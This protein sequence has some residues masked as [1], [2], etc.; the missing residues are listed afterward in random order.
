[1]YYCTDLYRF[2]PLYHRRAA[3][4]RKMYNIRGHMPFRQIDKNSLEIRF[5]LFKWLHHELQTITYGPYAIRLALFYLEWPIQNSPLWQK[6]KDGKANGY[7]KITWIW[8]FFCFLVETDIRCLDFRRL[9]PLSW[10]IFKGLFMAFHSTLYNSMHYSDFL[11][12][13]QFSVIQT[14]FCHE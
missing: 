1:M 8:P 9:S 14:H 6:A 7:M 11:L 5:S 13:T 3:P 12:S 2:C 10:S 4:K